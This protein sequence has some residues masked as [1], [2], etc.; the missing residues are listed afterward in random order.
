MMNTDNT[1]FSKNS[2]F[3]IMNYFP[4][5]EFNV[6]REYGLYDVRLLWKETENALVYDVSLNKLHHNLDK[7]YWAITPRQ[8]L[9]NPSLSPH[10]VRR[11]N[12][13][14]LSY[15]ILV[16]DNNGDLDILDGLH[17]LCKSI[18]MKKETIQVKYVTKNILMKTRLV[19]NH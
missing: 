6:V 7:K 5:A 9:K 1:F 14:N 10:H 11:V 16:Y 19:N 3:S 15:P 4:Y 8:L 12:I 2:R 17:R 13:S 18:L